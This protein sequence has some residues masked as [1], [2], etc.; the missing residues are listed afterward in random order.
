MKKLKLKLDRALATYNK[1]NQ[2]EKDFLIS[3]YGE[4]PFIT[5]IKDRLKDYSSACAILKRKELT[6][7]QFLFL[8]QSQAV[9]QFARHKIQT[10]IEA[11]NEG[12][13][14]DYD[15]SNE[16]KYEIWQRGKCGSFS[17]Y[18]DFCYDDTIVGSDLVC[19]TREKAEK[20][21]EICKEEL[22]TYLL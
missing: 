13:V 7:D 14:P 2:S 18:V 11:I 16:A 22:K 8:G 3:L 1:G 21:K 4:E 19:Q 12:W 15:N 17:S 6:V 9:K 5:D 10:C 20:I